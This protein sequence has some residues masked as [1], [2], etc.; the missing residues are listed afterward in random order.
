MKNMFLVSVVFLM[1]LNAK[2]DYVCSVIK[3]QSV[4]VGGKQIR[5]IKQTV[6]SSMKG[7][8]EL[9]RDE[10]NVIEVDIDKGAN[11]FQVL[12]YE[13]TTSLIQARAVVSLSASSL[14][15]FDVQNHQ[16]IICSPK[17]AD[18]SE[19]F[20]RGGLGLSV[21]YISMAGEGGGGGPSVPEPRP[22]CWIISCAY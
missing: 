6:S 4:I 21:R 20:D 16:R 17:A 18:I 11:T 8:F 5:V 12:S 14:T 1:G 2:A 13:P 19:N 9:Y 10:G 3:D 15:L 22:G 7:P